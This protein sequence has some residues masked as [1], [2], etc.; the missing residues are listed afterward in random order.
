MWQGLLLGLGLALL[1][2]GGE[3]LVRGAASLAHRLGVPPVIVGLTVVAFGTSTPELV[4]NLAA[5]LRGESEI[6]FGNV[7]GSNIANVGLL[8]AIGALIAPLAIHQTIVRREIPMLLL[9]TAFT[10]V[11]GLDQWTGGPANHFA[12]GDGIALL[13]LFAVFLYYTLAD[14]RAARQT[15]QPEQWT[16]PEASQAA[17]TPLAMAG[18]LLGGLLLLIAGG[19]L[20]VRGA[21]HLAQAIGLSEKVI[22]LTLV[23]V[24]TSLPELAT[25]LAA[26]RQKR[27]DLAVGNIVG[28]NIYNLLGIA[29]L[30][31]TIAPAELPAGG[32]FD[33]IVMLL[34][35]IALLPMALTQRRFGRVEAGAL[36]AGYSAY[37]AALA[38][39]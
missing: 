8:L 27:S 37:V 21:G 11:L 23:A 32:T 6:G 29:G 36:L 19:E 10:L 4:V 39:L 31:L 16:T 28:S 15:S 18:L 38:S 9:A 35:A 25:T 17:H 30:T 20:T 24:G 12:R 13:M 26:A 22:G 2:G 14:A 7:V 3:L 5:A 34:F 1:I 33:L